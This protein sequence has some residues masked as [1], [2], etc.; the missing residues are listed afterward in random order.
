[1]SFWR[2]KRDSRRHST[3]HFRENIVVAE[4]N[5]K[6]KKFNYF[7]I[8]RGLTFLVI[9]KYSEAFWGV[10]FLKIGEN[11]VSQIKSRTRT[12]VQSFS[13][14]NHEFFMI[15]PANSH[16]KILFAIIIE[17]YDLK[18]QRWSPGILAKNHPD[19]HNSTFLT[20]K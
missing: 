4:T 13:Y 9:K 3:M 17:C 11:I 20:P 15:W 5:V 12:V 6:C 7:A 10:Y 18:L 19:K 2:E 1:M 8:G 14:S 16:I